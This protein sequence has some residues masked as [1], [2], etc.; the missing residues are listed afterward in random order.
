MIAHE[1]GHYF[2]SDQCSKW[3]QIRKYIMTQVFFQITFSHF[4][5]RLSFTDSK[6]LLDVYVQLFVFFFAGFSSYLQ[7]SQCLP[8]RQARKS[9]RTLHQKWLKGLLY[10]FLKSDSNFN[11]S[12]PTRI[13]GI[14]FEPSLLAICK[15][16]GT[17]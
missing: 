15:G 7:F 16:S 1:F 9:T 8:C 13:S 4:P 10:F 5:V 12:A 14:S 6:W 3:C 11:P 17:R 2:I